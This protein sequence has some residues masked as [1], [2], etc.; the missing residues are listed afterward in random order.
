MTEDQLFNKISDISAKN[1]AQSQEFAREEM[2]FNAAEA[3][4]NRQWQAE[5]SSTAHQREVL[6][7]QKA[8]LNP[9][10]AAGGSGAQTGSGATASGA[11]GKV[12][13]SVVPALTSIIVNQQNNANAQAIAQMQ[14]DAT[15]EAARIS[16]QTALQAA[17]LQ[18]DAHRF[19]AQT[20]ANASRYSAD[21]NYAASQYAS[22]MSYQSTKYSSNKSYKGNKYSTDVKAKTDKRGQNANFIGSMVNS[23]AGL[24]GRIFG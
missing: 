12:D 17:Q 20:S 22:N 5:Q 18:A 24:L 16:Q 6:D 2:K 15:L 11:S 4:K 7:L 8:G 9:V 21:R 14:R 23:A 1:T 19:A 10:L 3:E 13:E